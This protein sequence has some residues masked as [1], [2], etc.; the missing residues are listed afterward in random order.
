ME[1]SF[2]FFILFSPILFTSIG[3]LS[4]YLFILTHEFAM[5]ITITFPLYEM[6]T[7]VQRLVLVFFSYVIYLFYF[8]LQNKGPR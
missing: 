6:F 3:L 1:Y 2:L 4:I 7:C 8:A 5:S